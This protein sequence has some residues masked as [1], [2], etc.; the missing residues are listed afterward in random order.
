MTVF[1]GT[2]EEIAL[3]HLWRW[4][5]GLTHQLNDREMRREIYRAELV[6]IVYVIHEYVT[7]YHKDVQSIYYCVCKTIHLYLLIRQKLSINCQHKPVIKRRQVLRN[8]MENGPPEK[9]KAS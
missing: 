5:A 6:F 3:K 9:E 7:H 2:A 4:P 1:L 8:E